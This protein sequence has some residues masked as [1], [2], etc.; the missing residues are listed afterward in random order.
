MPKAIKM[1]IE[2]T[3]EVY[4]RYIC[5]ISEILRMYI[6]NTYDVSSRYIIGILEIGLMYLVNTFEV[7]RRYIKG[8]W[9]W[10]RVVFE[11]IEAAAG[12]LGGMPSGCLPTSE[13][14]RKAAK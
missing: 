9:R 12:Y 7:Y 5:S 13:M 14:P 2:D 10:L 4:Q 3:F 6:G 8:C 11:A 1:Y